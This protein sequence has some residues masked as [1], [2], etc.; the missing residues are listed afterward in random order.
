MGNEEPANEDDSKNPRRS[1]V[2]GNEPRYDE[3]EYRWKERSKD[4]HGSIADY[5]PEEQIEE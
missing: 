3:R 2:G 1:S 4:D 5:P